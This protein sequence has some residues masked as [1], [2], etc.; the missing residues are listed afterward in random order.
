[1]NFEL[2]EEQLQIKYSIREFAESEIK[3]HVMEWDEAQ[4]FPAE[5]RPK[6]AELGLMAMSNTQRSSKRSAAFA[7]QSACR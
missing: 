3:P 2:N 4:H 1:M 6:L 5:L 7:V